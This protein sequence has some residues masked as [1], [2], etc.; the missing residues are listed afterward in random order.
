MLFQETP[1]SSQ[2][3]KYGILGMV[4]LSWAAALLGLSDPSFLASPWPR[5]L[6]EQLAFVVVFDFTIF[7]ATLIGAR[8][9]PVDRRVLFIFITLTLSPSLAGLASLAAVAYLIC[10]AFLLGIAVWTKTNDDQ[11]SFALATAVGLAAI[12]IILT[13]AERFPINFPLFFLLVGLVPYGLLLAKRFREK[14]GKILEVRTMAAAKSLTS[15]DVASE[16]GFC[17]FVFVLQ[18]H[19]L[20]VLLPER[21]YDALITHLYIPSFVAANWRWPFDVSI[22]AFAHMPLTVDFVYTFVF[23]LAGEGGARLFNFSAFVLI[24]CAIYH[25]IRQHAGA[26]I[27]IWSMALFASTPIALIESASLFIENGLTLWIFAAGAILI[28]LWPRYS[29]VQCVPIFIAV[30]AASMSKLHG[31]L[32]AALI[33]ACLFVGY[34]RF[35][36]DKM[37]WGLFVA[38]ALCSVLLGLFPY[39]HAWIDTGNPVFPFF[40][41][42]FKSQYWPLVNFLDERWVGRFNFRLLWDATFQSSNF[43]E[44]GPG[45]IGIGFLLLL[46]AAVFLAVVTLRAVNVISLVIAFGFIVLVGFQ[47]QYLRYF[48]PVFPFLLVI[49]GMTIQAVGNRGISR[50]AIELTVAIAV[51][52]N[53][54]LMPSGGWILPDSDFRAVYDPEIRRRL[55]IAQVPERVAN[56]IINELG[57]AKTRVLYTQDPF[58]ALLMGFAVSTSWYSTSFSEEGSQIT[59]VEQAKTLIKRM[60]VDYAVRELPGTS[61]S[62]KALGAFLSENALE[63]D[64]VGSIII[65]C[66]KPECYKSRTEQQ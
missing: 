27:A 58:G 1:T 48:Y 12:A 9:I 44:A 43:M 3:I 28:G 10:G 51:M 21:Y 2:F 4:I 16:I 6:V 34:V 5:H 49:M 19:F 13:L 38:I 42:I 36:R 46:P 7:A 57:G 65:Y 17:V 15:M 25:V 62:E 66:T 32:A 53:L 40:N 63:V 41:A 33:G 39:I 56:R 54:Y 64:H 14:L 20:Y 11:P 55:E 37:E 18:I 24:C 29:A 52:F 47:V 59:T 35:S 30:S 60:E 45:V 8:Y 50:F 31:L 22:W 26:R 61:P 23:G